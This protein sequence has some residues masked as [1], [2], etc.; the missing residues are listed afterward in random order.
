MFAEG[1]RDL[2]EEPDK[3][4]FEKRCR[5]A[6]KLDFVFMGGIASKFRGTKESEMG[7]EFYRVLWV[8]VDK[9]MFLDRALD[10]PRT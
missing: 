1:R 3:I 10:A 7:Q 8:A 6:V 5:C 4:A 2:M 9:Q